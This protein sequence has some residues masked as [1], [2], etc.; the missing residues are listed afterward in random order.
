M[1][2]IACHFKGPFKCDAK[3]FLDAFKFCYDATGRK[4]PAMGLGAILPFGGSGSRAVDF[5]RDTPDDM[6]ILQ[7]LN[8]L[9][10]KVGAVDN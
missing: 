5:D 3:T 2:I 6:K 4:P 1:Q 8:S 9:L 10:I 7:G